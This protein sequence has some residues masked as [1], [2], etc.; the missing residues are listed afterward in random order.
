[1][2]FSRF[3]LPKL[4]PP[5]REVVV[6]PD[7]RFFLRV[8]DLV[9]D[10]EAGPVREQLELAL[11]GLAPFPLAQMWWGYW[12]QPDCD[13]AL[14]FATYQKRFSA[15][16]T[17]AWPEA[18]WVG[19]RLACLLGTGTPETDTTWLLSSAEGLTAVHFGDDS[20]VPT[21]V[22]TME[23]PEDADEPTVAQARDAL[24]KACGGSREVQEVERT[25]IQA[26]TPGTDELIMGVRETRGAR[27]S[28]ARAQELDV[29]DN[30]ELQARRRAR[31]RDRWMWRGMVA[32]VVAIA[33]AG[34]AEVALWGLNRWLD[35][36]HQQVAAQTPLVNE[37][38]TADRLANRI[39]ELRTQRLRPFEMI[40][41]ADG[42]RPEAIVFLRT[43]A[44]GLYSL[45]IEA[46]TNDAP[47]INA[48][49]AALKA[50]SQ[51]EGVDIL[52]L[53]QRGSRSTVRV[54]VRFNYDAFQSP[55]EEESA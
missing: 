7:Q 32:A 49:V 6:L 39:D 51:T 52:N 29:R 44:T 23:V 33:F 8:V 31:V 41:I 36:M 5:M 13:H 30:D 48:Y 27:V 16:E 28:L 11:E 2:N 54:L 25:L 55:T 34:V 38:E 53:D 21:E 9:N 45:E 50:L 43:E 4:T 47:S 3:K 14:I 26:G 20:G 1:M 17:E 35:G 42:P 40:A 22:R 46:E 19:P 24:V 18:E 15:E 10:P 12:T 37:I